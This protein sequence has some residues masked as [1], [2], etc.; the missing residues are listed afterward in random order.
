[1]VTEE[2]RK[3]AVKK[4]FLEYATDHELSAFDTPGFFARQILPK[5]SFF[6]EANVITDLIEAGTLNGITLKFFKVAT[7][8]PSSYLEIQ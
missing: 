6:F 5:E 1:M 2:E 3:E 8:F 4:A 7:L